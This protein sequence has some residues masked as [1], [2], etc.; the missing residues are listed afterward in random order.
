MGCVFVRVKMAGKYQIEQAAPYDCDHTSLV[1]IEDTGNTNQIDGHTQFSIRLDIERLLACKPRRISSAGVLRVGSACAG[2]IQESGWVRR[3]GQGIGVS[4]AR[5]V[6]LVE[7]LL[8]LGGRHDKGRGE[9]KVL[10]K[11]RP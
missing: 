11:A 2:D 3:R 8:L 1:S 4:N 6:V 10:I 5:D 7:G 9:K